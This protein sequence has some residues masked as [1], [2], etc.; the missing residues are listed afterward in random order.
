MAEIVI[1]PASAPTAE[2]AAL[3]GELDETLN[4]LYAPEQRHGLALA[5]LFQ[6][7]IR[8]LLARRNGRAVG[9]GGVA[10][11][12]GFA[13]LKRMYV[14]PEARG[15]GVADALMARLTAEARA[16]GHD[17]L[18]L[19]TAVHQHAA[20]GLYRRHGFAPCAAFPPYTALPPEAVVTSVFMEKRL[21][22]PEAVVA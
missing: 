3:I 15:Q 9:C 5:A 11:L 14:R 13:E 10:F 21:L 12:D 4:A 7:H 18:R 16:M 17:L 8:L 22:P 19:E 20:L 6:P 1:V 2:V